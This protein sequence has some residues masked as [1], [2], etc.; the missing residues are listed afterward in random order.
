MNAQQCIAHTLELSSSS[1][2][3][4]SLFC[5]CFKVITFYLKKYYF[6]CVNSA[7]EIQ[8][9]LQLHVYK[10]QLLQLLHLNSANEEV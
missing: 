7:T 1:P 2:P 10:L 4:I 3:L 6:L 8:V 5:G 9:M